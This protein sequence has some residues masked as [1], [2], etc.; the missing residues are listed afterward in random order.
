MSWSFATRLLVDQPLMHSLAAS[1]RPRISDYDAQ[2]LANTAW[3]YATRPV[4]HSEPLL[5]AIAAS[6]RRTITAYETQELSN[7]AWALSVLMMRH[8]MPFLEAISA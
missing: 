8:H 2:D 4:C 5:E 6:S 7:T 3:A 1:A